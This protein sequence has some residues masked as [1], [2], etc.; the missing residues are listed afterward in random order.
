MKMNS[1][2]TNLLAISLLN[3]IFFAARGPEETLAQSISVVSS[4]NDGNSIVEL[5]SRS[6]SGP[7]QEAQKLT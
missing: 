6:R 7:G 1:N 3:F 4:I 5:R 2:L